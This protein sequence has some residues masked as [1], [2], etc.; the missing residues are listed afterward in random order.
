MCKEIQDSKVFR[1]EVQSNMQNQEAAIKKLETQIGYLFKQA[2]S[3]NIH[4]NTNPTPRE[5]C[6]AITLRNGKELRETYKKPQEKNS[7]EK[8]KGTRGNTSLHP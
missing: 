7:D 4:S 2:P 1:E 8:E 5:E 6:Q 3:H